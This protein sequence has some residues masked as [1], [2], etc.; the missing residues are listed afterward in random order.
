M[1]SEAMGEEPQADAAEEV[2]RP[3]LVGVL[4]PEEHDV[5]EHVHAA[6]DAVV[7][8][9]RE[10]RRRAGR[11]LAHRAALAVHERRD[12]PV[13]A[14]AQF[15]AAGHLALDDRE[16]A[17]V[18]DVALAR[19]AHEIVGREAGDAAEQQRLLALLAHALDEVV[20][21][22]DLLDELRHLLG[23]VL[24]VAVHD[25]DVPAPRMLDAGVDGRALAAVARQED[26]DEV[27]VA[28]RQLADDLRGR[29]RAAVVDQHDLVARPQPGERG[30]DAAVELA[31]AELLVV[32]GR[33]DG[34][35]H[36][37]VL[38]RVGDCCC[39]HAWVPCFVALCHW[40]K[41][42]RS[43]RVAGSS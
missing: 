8:L 34:D 20:A 41:T 38:R 19:G 1:I 39:V 12:E 30:R 31:H 40:A 29:V 17:H 16:P 4:E 36:R 27:G 23:R 5:E 33:D 43:P 2:H 22:A 32:H 15:E 21:L 42:G 37:E 13:L 11:H 7:A 6:A 9:A 3:L 25:H 24:Q 18:V 28:G 35:L 10:A 14:L 26:P